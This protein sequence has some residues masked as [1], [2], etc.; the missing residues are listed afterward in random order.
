MSEA[1]PVTSPEAAI[2]A[3][4]IG[5]YQAGYDLGY[6]DGRAVGHQEGV[7]DASR[8][9]LIGIRALFGTTPAPLAPVGVK[10][11]PC[12]VCGATVE[13]D[14]DLAGQLRRFADAGRADAAE[15]WRAY[16]AGAHDHP[17]TITPAPALQE[18]P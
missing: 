17:F 3:A 2:A 14:M 1:I 7:N 12:A 15:T 11:A 8:E 4:Y 16:C 5:G 9:M 6:L 10:R 13:I 18:K